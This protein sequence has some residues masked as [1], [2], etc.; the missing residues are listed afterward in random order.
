M[1]L[2]RSWQAE[3]RISSGVPN[4]SILTPGKQQ[5]LRARIWNPGD[6]VQF[7]TIGYD[8]RKVGGHRA[9]SYQGSRLV[10]CPPE[11]QPVL[12]AGTWSPEDWVQFRVVI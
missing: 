11:E 5:V 12:C 10:A 9:G 4:V 8:S 1:S 3:D 6:G 2:I 7:R